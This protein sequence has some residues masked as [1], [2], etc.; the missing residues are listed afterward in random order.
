M[1]MAKPSARDIDAGYDLMNVLHEIDRRWGGPWS[2]DGP[3]DLSALEDD[4]DADEPEHLA[5]LYNNLA[6]LLR[7]APGFPGRVLGG[8]CGVICYEK[9]SFWTPLSTIWRCTLM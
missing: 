5:A 2:I 8:M 6:K 3:E 9:T 7:R 4:F 1:K